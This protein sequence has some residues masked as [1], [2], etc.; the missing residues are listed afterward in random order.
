VVDVARTRSVKPEFWNDEKTGM[1]SSDEKCL[2]LGMLNFADD[3][4]LIKANPLFLKA[5][6]FPYDSKMTPKKIENILRTF[7]ERSLVYLYERNKQHY[8]WIIKFRV[9]QRIDKPQKPNNP[10]PNISLEHYRQAIMGR[11]QYVCHI[12]GEI[13]DDSNYTSNG[14]G[15]TMRYGKNYPSIDHIR[16][17]SKGGND[18]PNN[19]KCACLSC[20]KGRKDRPIEDESD[21]VLRPFQE[22][23]KITPEQTETETETETIYSSEIK[24]III[25]LNVKA[26]TNYRETSEATTKLLNARLKDF[27]I[28]EIKKVIDK[29]CASWLNDEK[30]SKYLR[31]STLFNKTK[32]EE[33]LNEPET[34]KT[35]SVMDYL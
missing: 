34:V 31:P 1:L 14:P 30:M 17:K 15:S 3:E 18:Y 22:H 10:A 16:P 26:G 20:N 27:T 8:A 13:T 24:N 35:E 6:I 11:D 7:Q 4:G 29:K 28:E 2:F 9:Y 5:S 19:L 25:Y 33:Y 32:F 12:C 21:V 23:S